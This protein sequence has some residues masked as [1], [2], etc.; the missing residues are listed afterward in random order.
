MKNTK[1]TTK[2]YTTQI[3]GRN[4]CPIDEYAGAH[5]KIMHS[6][7]LCDHKWSATP[8]SIKNG[9]GCP[10]CYQQSVRKPLDQVVSE[11]NAIDWQLV[12]PSEY[13]NSY[14]PLLL[15]HVCGEIV[16]SN[17]DRIFR[18]HKRCLHCSPLKIR[19]HW[20]TP[21]F[22][23]G[24]TYSSKLEMECCEYLISKFGINDITLQ[25]PYSI[26]SKQTADAYIK[27]LDTYVEISSINKSFYLERILNKRNKVRNFIFA[28]SFA[29]I[30][31]F[32]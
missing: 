18:K 12:E 21:A 2:E 27:S 14:S 11:L 24:R 19:K 25:K 31:L 5:T 17:L 20:S 10:Q 29:Q 15:K 16:K 30:K 23:N 22:A 1:Y 4:I 26:T 8:G 6:C 28:S 3:S 7:L 13:K 32:F 9:H